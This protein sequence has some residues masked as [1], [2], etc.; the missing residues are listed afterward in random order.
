MQFDDLLGR[1]AEV[2]EH[3]DGGFLAACPAHADSRPSLRIWVGED[4][5]VRM[6]CRAGCSTGAVLESITLPWGALFD[7]EGDVPTIPSAKPAP[8][9]LA[10]IAGLRAWLDTL[11]MNAATAG[12]AAERFGLDVDALGELGIKGFVPEV[13]EG[14]Y[15]PV[16]R[17]FA[18][19]PRMVVPLNGF[20]GV[21]RGAQGRDLSGQCAGRWISL[22]NPQGHRWSAHGVFRGG[23]G[24]NVWIITEGPGDALTAAALGY[25]TVAV[26]GASLVASPD[27]IKEIADGCQRR[28]VIVAGDADAAGQRFNRAVAEG[29]GAHGVKVMALGLPDDASDLTAWREGDP[30]GFAVAFHSAV[31]AAAPLPPEDRAGDER[32][33]VSAELAVA[34]GSEVVSADQGTEAARLL[35][36][37]IARYGSTD[38]MNAHALVAWT[39]G[40]I[41]YA[42]GL[43]FYVWNGTVWERSE[44]KVRQEIHRMGAALVLAGKLDQARP[45]L[46]TREIDALMTELR[47]VPSV[48]VAASDFDARP[49][50]L[51][52][53]NGTVELRTGRLRAHDKR[54]MLTYSL[55]INYDADAQCPRWLAFLEEVFPDYPELPDYI[56]RLFGY[57]ITGR[58][59]EQCFAVLWGKGANGKSVLTETGSAVFS[60]VAKTTPFATFEEKSS[61][62]IPNDIASLRGA[63]LVMASEGESGKPMSEAV[64]KRVTGKDMVSARFLRQEF[65][66]FR[67]AFLLML[68]TN[69]KPRFR[70]QDEGLWRRVKMIPFTRWFAPHERDTD[71]DKKLLSEA[72]GI[73]AWAVRGAMDWYA[74]G[75]Q[76]PECIT[77]ATLEYRETSD[78]LAGFFPGVL[79]RD[80]AAR[81]DGAKAFS[82]YLD[83]CEAENLPTRERWT[84][85]TFYS[86]M[87]E[88]KVVKKRAAKGMVLVGVRL[89]EGAPAGGPGIF[90]SD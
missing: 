90:G 13:D 42:P 6:T 55:A 36:E 49:D 15:M 17:T 58:T 76:D 1:F 64:L 83:W 7:I 75:L 10:S 88:R 16:S 45:F 74:G 71:L 62:G 44:V 4:R 73:A 87:E 8:V 21:T 69:H 51:S 80:D 67:P 41:R 28:L 30:E 81:I 46:M 27:L 40:R 79:A 77:T 78:A 23:A 56:Q 35:A 25:D 33:A 52:F 5:K 57:G 59:D 14:G 24:Y 84:R 19:Y 31:K 20:D 82:A 18:R 85:Q 66:E 9:G 22:S 26:R 2:S 60:A 61:G 38:A 63:R 53:A 54:D 47:S 86:A 29:L 34:T 72:E 89:A 3:D 68:A 65:F 11:S 32:A 50:L 12:Y 70:G 43:G 48:Y 39:D 37:L